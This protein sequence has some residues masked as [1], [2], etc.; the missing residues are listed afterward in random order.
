MFCSEMEYIINY[1]RDNK[2]I[3]NIINKYLE[4]LYLYLYVSYFSVHIYVLNSIL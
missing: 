2:C 3:I 4:I 1:V